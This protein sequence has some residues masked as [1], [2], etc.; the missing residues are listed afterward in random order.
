M[1]PKEAAQ[2]DPERRAELRRWVAGAI[3]AEGASSPGD[4][5]PV[6]TRRLTNVE[7]NNTVRDLT[8]IDLEPARE[9]PADGAAGE[10]FTNVSDALVMSPAMLDKYLAA[11]KG[12]AA[13]AVLLPDGIRFSAKTT[14]PDWTDEILSE[15]KQ[16]YQRYTHP[17]GNTQV[18]LQGIVW[19]SKGGGLIPLEAYL[20]ATI[21]YRD[22]GPAR[23][24]LEAS[25]PR[26]I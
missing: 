23:K 12:I 3:D 4:P 19:D 1:P 14:R 15:I 11:A 7:Y 16:V 6:V 5:G 2:P 21:S 26:T 22:G 17:G 8:A 9:F 24:G 25:R 13:H 10:G 18:K 20:A